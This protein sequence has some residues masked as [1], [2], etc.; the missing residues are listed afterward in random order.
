MTS[1][2]PYDE[3]LLS[4]AGKHTSIE[5]LLG[6]FISFLERKTDFFDV[7][8]TK[9]DSKGF[10]PGVAEA[11]LVK[12]FREHQGTHEKRLL[13]Q[14]DMKRTNRIDPR[15]SPVT[16]SLVRT[17]PSETFN[18][19]TT[20]KYRWSQ[21][22]TDISVEIIVQGFD[23]K[24]IVSICSESLT[25]GSFLQGRF[26]HKVNVSESVWSCEK[27]H[28]A[29]RVSI[30]IEKSCSMFWPCLLVGE[31]LIDLTKIQNKKHVFDLDDSGK[32]A[33]AKILHDVHSVSEN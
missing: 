28:S 23:S 1:S 6:T 24:P 3:I 14:Q 32:A 21:T 22:M 15:P 19:G 7:M 13:N 4:I 27:I 16:D 20:D 10:P 26:P 31:S 29:Y 18:G 17:Q 5:A 25:V 33:V 2:G 8:N 9:V 30:S 11:I 12:V